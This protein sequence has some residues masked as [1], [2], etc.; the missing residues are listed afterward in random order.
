[1][2]GRLEL[3][4]ITLA[5]ACRFVDQFHRHCAAP[6]GH[7]FSVAAAR[8]GDL[9]GVVIVGRPVARGNDDG[10]T[11]E[12]TRLCIR[13]GQKNAASFL[14]GAAARA[15]FA[16]GYRRLTT[17]TLK[18]EGGASLRAA[19]WAEIAAIKGRSWSCSARPRAENVIRDKIRWELEL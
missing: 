11:L 15:A 18:T 16:M 2:T 19:G 17:Y 13:P 6:R 10:F 4:P 5:E 3:V 14:L 9:A 12:I 1:M 8:D 7:K